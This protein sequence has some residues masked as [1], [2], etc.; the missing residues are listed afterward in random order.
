SFKVFDLHN[1]LKAAPFAHGVVVHLNEGVDVVHVS[2]RGFRPGNVVGI[3]GFQVTGLVVFNE[4]AQ[5]IGLG[6]IFSHGHGLFQPIDNLLY[7]LRV[8]AAHIPNL[9]FQFS[10]GVAHHGAVEAIGNGL[11]VIGI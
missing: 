8:F 6:F 3:P 5:G 9:F 2:F 7:S 11:G 10:F 4:Q 1:A